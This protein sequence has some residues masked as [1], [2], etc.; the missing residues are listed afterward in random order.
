[1]SEKFNYTESLSAFVEMYNEQQNK[2]KGIL[3]D[4][5][6]SLSVN[7]IKIPNV[8]MP[9]ISAHQIDI[10]PLGEKVKSVFSNVDTGAGEKLKGVFDAINTEGI[11]EIP[12]AFDNIGSVTEKLADM[13]NVFTDDFKNFLNNAGIMIR[14]NLLYNLSVLGELEWC[15]LGI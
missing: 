6:S 15:Y 1:M 2:I 10:E 11:I 4:A 9:Q 8:N 14:E 3:N 7:S 13:C 5:V 12:S